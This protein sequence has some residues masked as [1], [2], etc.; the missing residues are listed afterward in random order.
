MQCY[1]HESIWRDT[2]FP[3]K[4]PQTQSTSQVNKTKGLFCSMI[5]T[6][7][8]AYHIGTKCRSESAR[9]PSGRVAQKKDGVTEN[10]TSYIWRCTAI[11]IYHRIVYVSFAFRCISPIIRGIS[12][13]VPTGAVASPLAKI[14]LLESVI[15]LSY[16][17]D[18]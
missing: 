9:A 2:R 14:Y 18:L 11:S 7:F 4:A 16:D 1:T 17:S 10:V 12:R 6:L 8:N 15:T 5:D 3:A 13:K